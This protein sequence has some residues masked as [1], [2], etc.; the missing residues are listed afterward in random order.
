VAT[1]PSRVAE[2]KDHQACWPARE[3][4]RRDADTMPTTDPVVVRMG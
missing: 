2:R 4:D 1:R 3:H